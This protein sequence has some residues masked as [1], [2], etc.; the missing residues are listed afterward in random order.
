M[1]DRLLTNIMVQNL[2]ASRDFYVSLLD[3]KVHFDSDWYVILTDPAAERF[4]L[5]L[6]E[7][8]NDLIPA[9][10]RGRPSGLYLTF[11]VADA[12]A[13]FERA[14]QQG[15]RIVQEP[16]DTFYG[17]RRFI[18]VDPDG[19]MVDISAPTAAPPQ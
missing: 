9:D 14:R 2:K 16:Q 1:V 4:E 6:I 12:D 13:A 8:S 3:L 10:L 19:L 11:V 15:C 5:G 18:T 17:Q 7:E